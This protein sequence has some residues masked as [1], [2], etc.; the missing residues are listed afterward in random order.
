MIDLALDFLNCYFVLSL[1]VG[2]V[3]II[4]FV[5]DWGFCS[6]SWWRAI[7]LICP[8][9]LVVPVSSLVAYGL[10]KCRKQEGAS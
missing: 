10:Y 6:R 3:S 8:L 1:L 9:S 7:V 2:L 4:G 5:C